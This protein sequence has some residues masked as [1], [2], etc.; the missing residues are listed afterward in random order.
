LRRDLEQHYKYKKTQDKMFDWI[1][2]LDRK[3]WESTGELE[4][5][6][7]SYVVPQVGDV[8]NGVVVEKIDL[9]DLSKQPEIVLPKPSLGTTMIKG[10]GLAEKPMTRRAKKEKFVVE[11]VGE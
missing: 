11:S 10:G 3:I 9:G 5:A 7:D 1:L 2:S 4:V 6:R 8:I